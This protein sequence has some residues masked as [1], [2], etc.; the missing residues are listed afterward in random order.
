M[1]NQILFSIFLLAFGIEV[2]V[3]QPM[4]EADMVGQP[5]SY[6]KNGVVEGCG[7]RVVGVLTPIPGNKT[8]KSF[9]I[10]ANFWKSGQALVKVIGEEIPVAD[11][12][13]NKARRQVLKN[14]WIKA[15]GK[16]P[17]APTEGEFK[18]SATDKGAY[19]FQANFDNS[20]NFILAAVKNERVQVAINWGE[21]VEWIY[22]GT[23]QL[24]EQE[25]IQ[26]AQCLKEVATD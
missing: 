22:S 6:S 21:K 25:K 11:P 12:V 2:S 1:K 16:A 10:S 5:L 7:V 4:I 19:L 9:D 13:P 8:F 26:I 17:A 3:A 20:V 18:P 14:G 15:E 24:S 23:V